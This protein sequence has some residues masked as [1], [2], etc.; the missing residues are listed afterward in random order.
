MS[1][2]YFKLCVAGIGI[3]IVILF[4]VVKSMNTTIERHLSD[5][6]QK[7]ESTEVSK[8]YGDNAVI[9]ENLLKVSDL[10]SYTIMAQKDG[11][12]IR[13]QHH[14]DGITKRLVNEADFISDMEKSGVFMQTKMTRKDFK[15]QMKRINNRI[16]AYEQ[17]VIAQP[18]N[19]YVEKKLQGLYRMKSS[20]TTLQNALAHHRVKK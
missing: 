17:K 10:S 2:K 16:E 14:W 7:K 5:K 4:V 3:C 20:I 19:K 6:T 8:V 11:L 1:K 12:A 13:G 15:K 18:G 9:E